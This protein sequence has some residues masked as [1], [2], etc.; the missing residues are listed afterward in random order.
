V[1]VAEDAL[2][3]QALILENMHDAVVVADPAGRIV[4]VNPAAERIT[5]Y[6]R[7]DLVGHRAE[8]LGD[9]GGERRLEEQIQRE[10]TAQGRWAGELPVVRADGS[11]GFIDLVVVPLRDSDGKMLGT[12]GVGRDVTGRREAEARLQRT[13]EQL[14]ETD[15]MRRQLLSRLV[16]AQEE[17]RQRIA[18][19]IHDDPIQQLYAADL[20]LGMLFERLTDPRQVEL[21][22]TVQA[23]LTGTIRR[24][25]QMLFELQPAS[26]ETGGLGRALEEFLEYANQESDT[27]YLLEDR[28]TIPLAQEVRSIAYRMVLEA[29]SNVRKHAAARTARVAIADHDD[30]VVCSIVDDGR[31][32]FSQDHLDRYRPGHLGLPAMR[33]RIELAGG[34]LDVRSVPGEGTTVEFWLPA[35]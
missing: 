9:P 18:A 25:R 15:R 17:E 29:V 28:L 33:E 10:I 13:V 4:D 8:F 11:K 2:H 34:R 16:A 24:L 19:E 32:F 35:S 22:E 12:V 31:G 23:I 27:A 3:R 21:L 5:G 14:R 1:R 7:A 30:G 20:R 26:L 6:A